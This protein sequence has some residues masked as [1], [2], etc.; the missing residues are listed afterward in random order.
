MRVAVV[1]EMQQ[2]EAPVSMMKGKDCP[3]TNSAPWDVG[4]DPVIVRMSLVADLDL[5]RERHSSLVCPRFLQKVQ[6][7]GLAGALQSLFRCD[8]LSQLEHLAGGVVTG[9]VR[10]E[11]AAAAVSVVGRPS[12]RASLK[13]CSLV[14]PFLL[15]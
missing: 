9:V 1:V 7:P 2:T 14:C 8:V 12:R 15:Q 10:G 5:A 13:H 11:A 6:C 3:S 4:D